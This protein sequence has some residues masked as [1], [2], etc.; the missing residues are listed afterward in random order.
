MKGNKTMK[1]WDVVWKGISVGEVL[2]TPGRGLQ[3]GNKKKPFKVIKKL[4]DRIIVLSG[5]Y[6][7]PLT[8]DCFDVIEEAF[9]DSPHLWL[10]VAAV[11]EIPPLPQSAD[12]LIRKRTCSNLARANYVCSILEHCGLVHYAMEGKRK[13]IVLP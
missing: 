12:E 5:A 8:R 4:S 13:G 2:F 1:W 6:S 7:I 10:R 3:G 11:K 9:A